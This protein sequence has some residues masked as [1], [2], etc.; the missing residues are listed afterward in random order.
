MKDSLINAISNVLGMLIT[1]GFGY[2]I[3][4]GQNRK[5]LTI[6]DRQLLSEDEKQFRAE[7]VAELQRNREEI[8]ALRAEVDTLRRQN[9][10]LEIENKQLQFKIDELRAELQRRYATDEEEEVEELLE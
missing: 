1:G 9:I 2:F 3:A 10:N 5:D 7:L 4:K 8:M 6:N